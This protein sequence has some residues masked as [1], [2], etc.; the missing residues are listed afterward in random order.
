MITREFVTAGR[1][2]FTVQNSVR[3]FTFKAARPAKDRKNENAP[4]FLSVMTGTDNESHYTYIGILDKRNGTVRF[5]K[6]S[7]LAQDDQRV[8]VLQFVLNIVWGRWNLPAGY[9]IRH[10]GK[11]GRCGRT[12]TNPDSLDSGIGPECIKA[13]GTSFAVPVHDPIAHARHYAQRS[14]DQLSL[15]E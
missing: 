3:H 13:V 15:Y 9:E 6:G 10:S 12:L 11:C 8:K 5:T 2:I 1:A 7:K 4:I 14:V